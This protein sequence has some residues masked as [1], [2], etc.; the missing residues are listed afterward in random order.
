MCARPYFACAP[1]LP[2]S[3]RDPIITSWSCPPSPSWPSPLPRTSWTTRSCP[4]SSMTSSRAACWPCRAWAPSAAG[5]VTREV[6][7]A[8]DPLKLQAMG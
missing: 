3:L 7:V 4:G 8:L 6:R 5:S 1:S 2:S